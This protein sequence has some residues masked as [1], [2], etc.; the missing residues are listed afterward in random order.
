MRSSSSWFVRRRAGAALTIA[1]SV[2]LLG[3]GCASG[4]GGSL[5]DQEYPIKLDGQSYTVG[6]KNT[7]SGQLLCEI[8]GTALQSVGADVQRRCSLGDTQAAR[9]ALVGHTIDMYWEETGTAWTT[10]FHQQPISGMSQQYRAVQQKDAA[11]NKIVWLEATWASNTDAFAV[12]TDKAKELNLQ[13]ISDMAGY[14]RSGKPGTVCLDS[15]YQ[16]NQTS[17]LA[18]LERTYGFQLTPDRQKV[19]PSAD[20]YPATAGQDCLFGKVSA[21]DPQVAKNGLTVLVDDKYY[22]PSFNDAITI[23][24]DVYDRNPDISRVFTPVA[25]QLTDPVMSKLLLEM[26]QG[27]SAHDV[28]VQWLNDEGFVEGGS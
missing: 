15:A 26:S 16:Q 28:A 24:K 2:G 19:L 22:H 20:I 10:L 5:S 6:G 9:Q 23:R 13:T 12:K 27:K 8:A 14:I 4:N 25:R 21:D 7:P 3:A 11:D 1:L 18:G 17:G